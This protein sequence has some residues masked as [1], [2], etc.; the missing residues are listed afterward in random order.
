M[1]RTFRSLALPGQVRRAVTTANFL[2]ANANILACK[3]VRLRAVQGGVPG[4]EFMIIETEAA[5]FVLAGGRSRRMGVDK[6]LLGACG[7]TLLDRAVRVVREAAGNVTIIGEPA[8]YAHLGHAVIADL[9]P[10]LGPLGGI[11]TG[12]MHSKRRWNLFIACDM[13]RMEGR[14]L[15]QLL[16]EARG[17]PDEDGAVAVSASGVEPLVAVYHR[18][19]LPVL[20]DA[21]DR[22]I[23]KMRTVVELLQVKLVVV[24]DHDKFCNIN[25]PEDWDAHG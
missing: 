4:R 17:S 19:A 16:R 2:T 5:G 3:R 20:T 25:T 10:G 6:A 7:D 12:I 22:N 13:P 9:R 21:L 18:R 23:L 14:L 15:K 1:E 11:V 24:P 8:R